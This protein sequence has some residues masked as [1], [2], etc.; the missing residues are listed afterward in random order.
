MKLL[1][2][3][4]SAD[5]WNTKLGLNLPLGSGET[6]Q[7]SST[8]PQT[9]HKYRS[10]GKAPE[11]LGPTLLAANSLTLD[12]L[13]QE[14]N[15]KAILLPRGPRRLRQRVYAR[16][17]KRSEGAGARTL[18]LR[19]KSPLLYRLSYTLG[20]MQNHLP[21]NRHYRAK[22]TTVRNSNGADRI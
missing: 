12:G 4:R 16:S 2:S 20:K 15:R 3:H 5:T 21:L 1:F 9:S 22:T 10:V 13:L 8:V 17:E 14:F 7:S 6:Q 19:I 18:D 11:D